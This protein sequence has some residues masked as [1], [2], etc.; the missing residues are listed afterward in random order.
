M[1]RMARERRV[2]REPTENGDGL[3]VSVHHVDLRVLT[4][5]FPSSAT[6][7]AVYHWIGSLCVTPKHFRLTKMPNFTLYA[8]ESVSV[9]DRELLSTLET[10]HI[11][12]LWGKLAIRDISVV[13]TIMPRWGKFWPFCSVVWLAKCCKIHKVYIHSHSVILL[14]FTN[15]LIHIQ[16]C[17]HYS[18]IY[19]FAFSN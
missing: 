8:D 1:L 7:S 11:A 10:F 18:R 6:M 12:K 2:P 17:C 19:W 4:W 9:A 5:S 14:L 16:W 13:Q 3:V 15:I